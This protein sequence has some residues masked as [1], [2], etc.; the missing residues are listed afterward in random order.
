MIYP[1]YDSVVKIKAIHAVGFRHIEFAGWREKDVPGILS[2]CRELNVRV[3]NFSGH[4]RGSIVRA[5]EHEQFFEDVRETAELAELFA[6]HS[7]MFLTNALSMTGEVLDP[8]AS[9]PEEKKFRNTVAALTQAV[10]MLPEEVM[11]VLEPLNTRVDHPGYYLSD[12]ETAARIIAEV[13]DRR[14]RLLCDLYHFGVMGYDPE[15]IIRNYAQ[16]IGHVHIA[17]FPGRHELDESS[18]R[19]ISYLKSLNA[20]G[21]DGYIGFEYVP[22]DDSRESLE[23]IMRFWKR[24]EAVVL[25]EKE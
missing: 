20:G 14:C 13:G 9:I 17:D 25:E 6:P 10:A 4:R 8:C 3:V 5:E 1:G 2:I 12:P 11:L 22:K 18:D 19:W 7:M 23:R 21:Y 24:F 15:D 16:A